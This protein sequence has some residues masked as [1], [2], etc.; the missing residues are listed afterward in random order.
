EGIPQNKWFRIDWVDVYLRTGRRFI[1][2]EPEFCITIANVQVA[3]SKKKGKG[4]F[5]R[6]LES[7][8][9][10]G[11]T[12]YIENVLNP[13]LADFFNRRGYHKLVTEHT[14]SFVSRKN[15]NE[16]LYQ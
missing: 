5:T 8:E 10:L 4:I 16:S 14:P 9:E 6:F 12:V 2:E 1:Y 11:Y 3:P 7:V 13:R 15:R